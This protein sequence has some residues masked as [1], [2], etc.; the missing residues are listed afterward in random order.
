MSISEN[1]PAD[2]KTARGSG[3]NLQS[4]DITAPDTKGN[5][6]RNESEQAPAL[7]AAADQSS[8]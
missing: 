3:G 1:Q 6:R 2:K 4:K 8:K 5:D 7:E